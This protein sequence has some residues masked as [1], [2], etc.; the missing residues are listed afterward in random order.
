MT[1]S[2]RFLSKTVEMDCGYA[3]KCLVF[4]GAKGKGGYGNF[5]DGA[6]YRNAHCVAYELFVGPIPTGHDVMHS[7]DNPSCCNPRHLSTGSRAQNMAD[8]KSKNR[9]SHGEA[10]G[11][12]IL[13][14]DQVREIRVHLAEGLLLQREI[15]AIYGVDAE[16]VGAIKRRKIWAWLDPLHL[17]AA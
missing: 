11:S 14:V 3:T 15:G 7:C 17:S 1:L 9:H 6:R 10:H 13:T 5:W 12:C 8:A 16:T 2:E 4:T